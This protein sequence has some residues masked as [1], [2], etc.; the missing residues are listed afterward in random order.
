MTT[1]QDTRPPAVGVYWID[2]E[3]YPAVRRIFDDGNKM[4]NTWREWLKMAEPDGIM[5]LPRTI[6]KPPF[7]RSIVQRPEF[8]RGPIEIAFTLAVSRRGQGA[9]ITEQVLQSLLGYAGSFIGLGSH[10]GIDSTP[11]GTP[12]APTPSRRCSPLGKAS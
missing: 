1:Q 7:E 5:D 8:V 11:A 6:R 12:A 10:R 3:D 4:P 2:E 9:I